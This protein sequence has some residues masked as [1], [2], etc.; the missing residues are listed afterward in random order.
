MST[1]KKEKQIDWAADLLDSIF[2]KLI[3]KDILWYK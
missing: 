2:I 1:K 3:K